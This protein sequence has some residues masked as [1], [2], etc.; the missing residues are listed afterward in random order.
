[1]K[2]LILSVLFEIIW[3]NLLKVYANAQLKLVL[4][5]L[6]ITTMLLSLYALSEAVK[7]LP[8]TFSYAVWT[9]SGLVGTALIQHFYF[10][11]TLSTQSW[12]AV[13]LI[14]IGIML[15]NNSES[16]P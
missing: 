3:V 2:Y 10:Q 14:V 9:S 15:F 11:N 16:A 7:T 8:L 13:V 12:L 1:M 5:L 4:M 6:V